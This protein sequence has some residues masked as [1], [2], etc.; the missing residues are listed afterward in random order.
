[1]HESTMDLLSIF[2]H[3]LY[4]DAESLLRRDLFSME[5]LKVL[6]MHFRPAPPND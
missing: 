6:S 5:Y 3:V 1:M 4:L 2:M